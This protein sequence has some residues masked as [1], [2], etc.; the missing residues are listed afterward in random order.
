MLVGGMGEVDS[1][2]IRVALELCNEL[3]TKEE[4]NVLAYPGRMSA[5]EAAFVN[6]M[7]AEAYL[8]EDI[9]LITQTHPG[10]VVVPAALAADHKLGSGERCYRGCCD[11]L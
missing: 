9:Y 5:L 10:T 8:E 6:E 4:A 1:P 7:M 3:K 2:S 11:R